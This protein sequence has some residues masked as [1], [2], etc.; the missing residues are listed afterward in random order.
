[1][2]IKNSDNMGRFCFLNNPIKGSRGRG[3]GAG[4]I[5]GIGLRSVNSA[6]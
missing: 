1:M 5:I 2:M 3:Y 4:N 6:D